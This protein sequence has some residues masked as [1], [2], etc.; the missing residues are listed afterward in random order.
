MTEETDQVNET[1]EQPLQRQFA[2][3]FEHL[4][5]VSRFESPY[6]LVLLDA[7]DN[8]IGKKIIGSGEK[9][10]VLSTVDLVSSEGAE[11][12]VSYPMHL[13]V[14]DTNGCVAYVYLENIDALPE[15][16]IVHVT[17]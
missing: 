10:V 5:N 15:I 13:I 14:R 8:V 6:I 9:K 1:D 17:E 12:G 4:I 3:V 16:Q 7:D 2:T 11:E